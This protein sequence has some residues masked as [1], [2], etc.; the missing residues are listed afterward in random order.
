MSK[1]MK[2]NPNKPVLAEGRLQC[3]RRVEVGGH[4]CS[5]MTRNNKPCHGNGAVAS[6][7][8][9]DEARHDT[10]VMA[11]HLAAI[12]ARLCALWPKG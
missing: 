5:A 1:T 3:Q 10:L 4:R 7:T 2:P 9:A 8:I 6:S 12:K 11:L